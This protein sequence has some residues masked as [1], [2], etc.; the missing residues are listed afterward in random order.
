MTNILGVHWI[1]IHNRSGDLDYMRRL[2]PGSVKI[3]DPDVTQISRVHEA[4]PGALIVLRN[5]PRSEQHDDV[6]RNSAETGKRHAQEWRRDV[7]R[8]WSE[9]G[10][11]GLTM[12]DPKNVIVLGINEPHVWSMLDQTVL[13]N[14]EF[15]RECARLGLRAGALNL[16][17]GWPANTGTDTPVDWKPYA[18]IEAA[19]K[20]GNHIL[21]LHEYF[22]HHG[23]DH[24]WRWWCGRYEQCP[25]QVPIIIGEAGLDEYVRD[26]GVG[27][28][29]RGWQ[30]WYNALDYVTQ[31]KVY[32]HRCAKDGR[33][34]SIQ[35]FTTDGNTSDWWSFETEPAHDE[36]LRRGWPHMRPLEPQQ[37]SIH[38]PT[39][40]VSPP[41]LMHVTATP[42]L[43]IRKEPTTDA[44]IVGTLPHGAA[45]EVSI[46]R[47]DWWLFD[48]GWVF[49]AWLADAPPTG[50]S[51]P[52]ET[53]D[54]WTRSYA[55]V[56][57]WEGGWADHP[58][59]PG[60]ATMKGI[61]LAT[62]TRW[63]ETQ[64]Q[65]K[66]TKDD[67]RNIS[68]AEVEAIYRA[69]YWQASGADTLPWPLCL[70]QF[71]TA[72]NAGVGKAQETLQRSNGDFLAYMGHLID[73]YTRINNFEHFGRAWI[74]RRAEILLEA[75]K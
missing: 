46:R 44:D 17:V 45:I 56:R 40:T 5:H 24:N 26:P 14:V 55:F 16:S 58:N 72:V 27:K 19:I 50:I 25:W 48:S 38:L 12:P 1:P 67:L 62:Y 53:N 57:R 28:D 49:G 36:I 69:W 52:V 8:Y 18:P 65:P 7:D 6:R 51:K 43:N 4:A 29:R 15:L 54:C 39:A 47:G 73:W 23:V 30:A 74:R 10:Q 20:D 32:A 41:R 70:A 35:V 9:A 64:R 63:R 22:S 60:G 11:R 68:E 37:P 61:T 31:L 13:Y 34:H 71:D 42:W 3:V 66:P 33:I 75:A 2:Q 59:D 21:F